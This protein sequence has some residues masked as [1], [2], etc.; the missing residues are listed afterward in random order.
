MPDERG[1]EPVRL[2]T[3][4]SHVQEG[5]VASVLAALVRFLF[6]VERGVFEESVLEIVDSDL[7]RFLVRDRAEVTRDLQTSLVRLLDSGGELLARDV[8]IGLERGRA[9]IRPECDRLTSV[10]RAGEPEGQR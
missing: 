3:A 10:L 2:G 7:R 9:V 8:L 1:D 6:G 5:V 4:G